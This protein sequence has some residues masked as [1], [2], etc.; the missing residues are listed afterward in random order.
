MNIRFRSIKGR[1]TLLVILSV[2][3]L[4]ALLV[5]ISYTISERTITGAYMNQL[6]NF[7]QKVNRDLEGFY[8]T[9]VNRA[10]FFAENSVVVEA[11][12]TGEY[13]PAI[14]IMGSFFEKIGVFENIFLSTAEPDSMIVADGIGG[15]SVDLKWRSE[16]FEEN[17]EK[18]LKGETHISS[19][20][21]SPVSD[22]P[23]VLITAPIQ[24]NGRVIGIF[25]L[26]IDLG[27]YSYDLIKNIKIGK[28]GY[29][30]ITDSK[31]LTFAHPDKERILKLNITE[32]E[33]GRDTLRMGG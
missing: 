11:M 8:E 30:F 28:T 22:K 16:V 10:L 12:E 1:I 19:P 9:N 17:I 31:G 5:G 6:E 29:P 4:T 26:P 32:Y 33:R 27:T 18:A 3:I 25:G 14:D 2:V 24:Q 7:D 15:K 13:G 21:K 23:V 20:Y